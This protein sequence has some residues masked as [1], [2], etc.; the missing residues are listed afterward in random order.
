MTG[1]PDLP[2]RDAADLDEA[3]GPDAVLRVLVLSL[4]SR[5]LATRG[6]AARRDGLLLR[7]SSVAGPSDL[8]PGLWLDVPIPVAALSGEAVPDALR[9]A[10][11]V[12]VLPLRHGGEEVGLVALG[13][14]AAGRV[15]MPREVAL[16]QSLATASAASLRAALAAAA[17][18]TANRAL[19]RRAQELRTLLD[20]SEA[21]GRDPD[22]DA[23]LRRL[24]FGLMG[25]LLV[26][27][28]AIATRRSAAA[29]LRVAHE[30]GVS[31]DAE[32][33]PL[34]LADADGPVQIAPG[35]ALA[36]AGLVV[37]VPLRA[38]DVSRGV[39]LLGPRVQTRLDEAGAGES[40]PFLA[41]LA[42]LVVGALET[43]DRVAER[44]ERERVS[45]ELRL[46]RV[47]QRGLLPATVAGP[48]GLDVEA[49]WRPSRA[50]AGDTYEVAAL[51][52]GRLLVAVADVVGK[53]LGA[54]LLMATLQAGVR[55]LRTELESA[56]ADLA[57]ATA[58]LNRLMAA[59]T[60]PHQFVTFAWAVVEPAQRRVRFVTAGHPP[61]L[62]LRASGEHLGLDVGGPLLGVL[63]DAVYA[64]GEVALYPGDVLVLY[65]DG[66]TE[67]QDAAGEEWGPE[68][69]AGALGGADRSSAAAVVEAVVQGAQAFG[70]D[71]D[72]EAD[73]ATLVVVRVAALRG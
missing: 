46:A 22:P 53:G 61:P 3:L 54:A 41:S 10:G 14:H 50:V 28:F 63:P 29:P 30:Q 20:L 36:A 69:L 47:I 72:G 34:A 5:M 33:I 64:T 44:V 27:R 65:T 4:M 55:L 67:V 45:E 21:F 70:A 73:D 15:Y 13:P 56:H 51:A 16:A 9:A 25:Q 58:R 42:A 19:E 71:G 66:L 43:A 68:G 52:D 18:A 12:L 59:S 49:F 60:E 32:E 48:P 2:A 7:L 38:G 39:A 23:I 6:L 24:G 1:A 8:V 11:M 35:S 26:S 31:V 57:A 37:A 40:E 17:L 62:L